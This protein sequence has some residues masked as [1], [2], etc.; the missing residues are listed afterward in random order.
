MELT[1]KIYNDGYEILAN[2]KV[3]ITQRGK[4]A[5]SGN[6]E[7]TA[8]SEIERIKEEA[9]RPTVDPIEER[10]TDVELATVELFEK[11]EQANTDMELAITE[12]YE[13]LEGG[14]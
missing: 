2:E 12:L 10:L 13:L 11:Q 14:I 3:W 9:E 8:K 7:E 4:Y 6:Y 5:P 1:Y